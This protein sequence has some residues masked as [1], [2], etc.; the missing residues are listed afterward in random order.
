M[1]GGVVWYDGLYSTRGCMIRGGGVVWYKRV[2]QKKD[3]NLMLEAFGVF[4]CRHTGTKDGLL[5]HLLLSLLNLLS[6]LELLF[7]LHRQPDHGQVTC[8]VITT[9]M[10]NYQHQ[11]SVDWSVVHRVIG[12]TKRV[13]PRWVEQ[14]WL[15]VCLQ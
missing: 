1:V 4:Y 6:L 8:S 11:S 7:V 9:V 10:S 12:L 2:Q 13:M 5:F 15:D 3:T 14:H